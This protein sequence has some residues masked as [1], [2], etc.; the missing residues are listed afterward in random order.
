MLER[1][2]FS[3]TMDHESSRINGHWINGGPS[4]GKGGPY[5]LHVKGVAKY[6]LDNERGLERAAENIVEWG[7]DLG[8][9]AL[10]KRWM[11]M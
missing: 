4:E 10:K 1:H 9:G 2:F 11:G 8:C 5:T 7:S 6:F 3:L